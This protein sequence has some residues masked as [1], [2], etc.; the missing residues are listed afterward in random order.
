[1]SGPGGPRRGDDPADP[2]TEQ[3]PPADPATEHLPPVPGGTSSAAWSQ[4]PAGPA[5]GA[6]ASPT[7]HAYPTGDVPPP[8]DIPPDDGDPWD[9]GDGGGPTPW[10]I[11]A[12]LVAIALVA[13]LVIWLLTATGGDEEP[14]AVP[15]TSTQT[16][17]PTTSRTTTSTTP[18]TTGPPSA[19][20]RCTSEFIAGELGRG[21]TVRECDERFLLVTR[22]SGE[23][24]L[25]SWRDD[26]WQFLAEPASEVCREQLQQLGV[27]D[28]F[29]RVFQPCDVTT[30]STTSSTS[31]TSTSRTT[32]TTTTGTTTTVT[33]PTTATSTATATTDRADGGDATGD[34]TS[35][36]E[37]TDAAVAAG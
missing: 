22:E 7:P 33:T 15:T 21:T 17:T 2:P 20:E 27:P 18:T 31:P 5:A 24:E 29:R 8:G 30:S 23:L 12:V 10:M 3:L 32:R 19:T 1:M 25:F 16:A 28:R 11:A 37:T 36:D 4:Y 26:S 6:A 13:A 9:D 34:D 35:G 14:V